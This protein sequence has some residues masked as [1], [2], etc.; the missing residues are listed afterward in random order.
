MGSVRPLMG[1]G[2]AREEAEQSPGGMRN[3]RAWGL[4]NWSKMC[5][6]A[7]GGFIWAPSPVAA[8]LVLECNAGFL[9]QT[10]SIHILFDD[11]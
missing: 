9:L 3:C 1:G 6:R 4:P 10:F 8:Q 5:P 7:L 2:G 11:T